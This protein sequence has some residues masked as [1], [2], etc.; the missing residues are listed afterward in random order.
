MFDIFKGVPWCSSTRLSAFFWSQSALDL[1]LFGQWCLPEFVEPRRQTLRA[2]EA[3]ECAYWY[4]NQQPTKKRWPSGNQTWLAGQ[5]PE[6]NEGLNGNII[7]KWWM[8]NCTP[9]ASGRQE[10]LFPGP[11]HLLAWACSVSTST[12]PSCFVSVVAIT[13]R[14]VKTSTWPPNFTPIHLWC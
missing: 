5:I 8:F 9:W 10:T 2:A 14:L 3:D 1:L 7:Y 6:P 4:I 13:W 12:N 11:G